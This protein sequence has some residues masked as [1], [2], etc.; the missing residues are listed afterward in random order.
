MLKKTV[1]T[2]R[3]IQR[4]KRGA[5][6]GNILRFTECYETMPVKKNRIVFE[7]FHGKNISDTPLFVL[8]ELLSRDDASKYEIFFSTNNPE[9][10][11]EFIEAQNLPV[12]L[13]KVD[14]K[15]Y[16]EVIATAEYLINNSS[17]PHWFIKRPEQTYVQT[18][19][20]VPLKTLGKRMRLGIESMYNVQHNFMQA[21][22]ITFPNEFTRNAIM[23]DYNLEELYTGRV[24]MVGYPRNDIF[25]DRDAEADI[26][27]R[28]L[29]E[30][31][32]CFAYMPT[33]RGTSNHSLD[34]TDYSREMR[35]LLTYLDGK[36]GENQILFVNFHSMLEGR[37]DIK[38]YRHIRP[39]PK[40]TNNY[41]FLNAMDALI[42]DYSSVFFDYSIT[43]KPIIL[44]T[45]DLEEYIHDR[46]LYFDINELPFP[47]VRTKEELADIIS[48]GAYSNAGYSGTDYERE[49]LPYEAPDNSARVLDLLLTGDAENVKLADMSSNREKQWNYLS[50]DEIPSEQ[51]L[52]DVCRNVRAD[53]DILILP[54]NSFNESMSAF[55]H[56][57]YRDSFNY[58]FAREDACI[59]HK[60]RIQRRLNRKKISNK[61]N[62]R[63]ETRLF[64]GL[65]VRK[66]DNSVCSGTVGSACC[67]SRRES[68]DVSVKI[69]DNRLIIE[70][71][72]N[73]LRLKLVVVTNSKDVIMW[74][75]AAD[76]ATEGCS[77]IECDFKDL[78]LSDTLKLRERLNVHLIAEEEGQLIRLKPVG[79]GLE[80]TSSCDGIAGS[81]IYSMD[82][83]EPSQIEGY[84]F[85]SSNSKDSVSLTVA[86]ESKSGALQLIAIHGTRDIATVWH[87]RV[88]RFAIKG[89]ARV[90]FD[91]EIDNLGSSVTG[92]FL[93]YRSTSEELMYPVE[94]SAVTDSSKHRVRAYFD[95][96]EFEFKEV[97]WDVIVELDVDGMAREVKLR[98]NSPSQRRRFRLGDTQIK[99]S[100]GMVLLAYQTM[101]GDLAF[102]YRQ[103]SPYETKGL[104]IKEIA[105]LAAYYLLYPY[106]AHRKIWIVY[107]KFCRLAQDNGYYFFDYCMQNPKNRK[108]IYYIIDH[109]SKDYEAVSRYGRNV[110]DFMSFR[111]ILYLLA[112]R[113][114]V[115][116]DSK[117][118]LY[119]WR[120]RPSYINDVVRRRRIFFLQHGVTAMKRVDP[121]FGKH[122]SNPMT[123]FVTTSVN[124]QNIVTKYFGY[125]VGNAPIAG[126]ARWDVLEDK[127]D[128]SK[129][130][131]LVMPTWRAW[132]DDSTEETFLA[133]DYFRV[134]SS[135][136]SNSDMIRLLE[137]YDAKLVFYIH[138]KLSSHLSLFTSDNPRVELIEQGTEKLNRI[139]MES[140]MIITDY[141]SV[142]WD[143]LYMDKPAAYYQFDQEKYLTVTGS[144]IDFNKEL[145][146]D[147]CFS[148]DEVIKAVEKA[149]ERGW[150]LTE[151]AAAK[152]EGWYYKKDKNNSK[153]TYEYLKSKGY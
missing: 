71:G 8:K 49:Y 122:G 120:S 65:N 57:N 61:Y 100:N 3:E 150:R 147:V 9:E 67:V 26:R 60:E 52:D 137:K 38:D 114:Y 35:G 111:H 102:T 31:K 32:E 63:N 104:R 1:K 2:L 108:R 131:I 39:F 64:A 110:V 20:G 5:R 113:V 43:R 27:R 46:G 36:L 37:I 129:P 89:A 56:D 22:I 134:Y 80:R 14:T 96:A 28:Y 138:P 87:G 16:A 83:F 130:K 146:G 124:E 105:A 88:S 41:E 29:L 17:F 133:S 50:Y 85:L 40:D 76:E 151:E 121:L 95:A 47:Q 82:S 51:F 30:G 84:R 19:H 59:T 72:K 149:A 116:S 12:K 139:M 44:Y 136:I 107:E 118:H 24:A 153:R 101:S 73:D 97:Q 125:T 33:W 98:C 92:V 34:V 115:G 127:S 132:L 68:L 145:P 152:C 81:L 140:S 94:Y 53:K 79:R 18:W 90:C 13:I 10:A 119:V 4:E 91:A 148:E 21:D 93:K 103:A 86:A 126:F 58:I 143:M 23:R 135:L 48:S 117:T 128:M 45:Y 70:P 99:L 25:H 62:R 142:A 69:E 123:H 6:S 144:Y 74:S 109:S 75:R 141:S 54:R 106:W 11:S 55:L 78:L 66:G 112:A 42:T 77:R 15:E 7:S